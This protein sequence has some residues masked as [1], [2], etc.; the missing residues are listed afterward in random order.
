MK[1]L[2]C[3]L[4]A[5][6]YAVAQCGPSLPG[7]QTA[8]AATTNYSRS[9]SRHGLTLTATVGRRSYPRNALVRVVVTVTNHGNRS[10]AVL[11]GS[12]ANAGGTLPV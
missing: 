4:F 8:H 2:A 5:S 12:C 11:L 6:F 1:V 7:S 10:Q 9:A 3:L